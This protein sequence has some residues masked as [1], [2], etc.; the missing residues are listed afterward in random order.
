MLI[1]IL[2]K[3]VIKSGDFQYFAINLTNSV[4][5]R[6]SCSR[7]S[8]VNFDNTKS[9]SP[10]CLRTGSLPVPSL[11]RGKSSLPSSRIVDFNPLFPPAEPRSRKRSLPKSRLK[12]SQ[13]MRR[14]EVVGLQKLTTARTPRPTSLQKVCGS[15]D[16]LCSIPVCVEKG[17]I[18]DDRS[19]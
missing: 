9:T 10:I 11:R 19:V 8:G 4:R 17:Q 15:Y 16:L 3:C 1:V 5:T 6:G 13:T 18:D 14:S 2:L 7:S 12:S